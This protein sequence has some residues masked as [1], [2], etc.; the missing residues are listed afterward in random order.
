MICFTQRRK[1]KK[2]GFHYKAVFSRAYLMVPKFEDSLENDL[3]EENF[4]RKGR[5]GRKERKQ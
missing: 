1:E 3:L 4:K 5:T 2:S